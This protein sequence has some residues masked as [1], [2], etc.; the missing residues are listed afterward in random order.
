M[1]EGKPLRRSEEPL[2]RRWTP[3]PTEAVPANT[4]K[5]QSPGTV[6]ESERKRETVPAGEAR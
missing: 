5:P 3:A 4:P 1:T 6:P 2:R